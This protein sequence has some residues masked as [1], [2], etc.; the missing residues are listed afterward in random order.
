MSQRLR[1]MMVRIRMVTMGLMMGIVWSG[2]GAGDFVPPPPPAPDTAGGGG[3]AGSMAG[4]SAATKGPSVTA[5]TVRN[6]EFIASQNLD[7]EDEAAEKSA[8][9]SQAGNDKARLHILPDDGPTSPDQS[10][11]RDQ[12]QVALVRGAVSRK[13]QAL[14]I[15]PDDPA[16]EELGRAIGEVLA[17]KI[18]VVVIGGPI[19]GAAKTPA[20]PMIMVRPESFADSARQIVNL[21][22]R[23][24]RNAKLN[25]E[26]GAI[27][28]ILEPGDK[29]MHDR[30]AAVRGALKS[31]K[32]TA[33]SE[34]R[35]P[36]NL[37]AAIAGLRKRLLADAKPALVFFFDF[38]GATASN[39]L[40]GDIVEE[41]PFVQAGY[42]SDNSL[43]RMALAGEFAAMA[44]FQ[45][46]RLIQKAVSAAVAVALGRSVKEK[47]ELPILLLE[48][49]PTSGTP[50]LQLNQKKSRMERGKG[51]G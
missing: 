25:P 40:A 17:A 33:V 18:P 39:N 26:G 36:R 46:S 6:V 21:A 45:P 14:I 2:C 22:I 50:R 20:A 30:V 7:P 11:A 48:S 12:S 8:A 38:T 27:L 51:G 43:P 47:E 10:A 35:L 13:P 29:F 37:D 24:A 9:R 49:P 19:A 34:L 23:N 44:E 16:S 42:T 1:S 32:I 28:L 31:A 3:A 15:E 41:R 5:S 4:S